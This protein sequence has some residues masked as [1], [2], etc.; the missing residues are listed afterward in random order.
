MDYQQQAKIFRFLGNP[1]RIQILTSL[2]HGP[3]CVS[4]LIRC[5]RHRQA[6]ISQQLMVLRSIGWVLSEKEGWSVCYR[7]ADTPETRW[8]K[9]VIGEIYPKLDC[10]D[11]PR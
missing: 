10:L 9:R 5:T 6:Y 2:A 3:L 4:D 11:A 7:L 1:V 8:L